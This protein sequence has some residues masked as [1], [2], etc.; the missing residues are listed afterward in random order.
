MDEEVEAVNN[1]VEEERE[2]EEEVF[3]ESCGVF[4]VRKK[5]KQVSGTN[6]MKKN[7]ECP[8]FTPVS[9]SVHL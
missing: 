2:E 3:Q 1:R 4:E 7:Q 5:T 9:T 6:Y 8:I